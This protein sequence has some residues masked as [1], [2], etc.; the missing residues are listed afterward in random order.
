[1]TDIMLFALDR[2]SA[3]EIPESA[4]PLEKSLQHL[5]EQNLEAMLGVRLLRSECGR[6]DSNRSTPK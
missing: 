4:A 2:G 3:S 5:V 1:M 6:I